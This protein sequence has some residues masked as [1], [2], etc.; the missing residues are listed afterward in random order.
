M[1]KRRGGYHDFS[2][3]FFCLTVP[4]NFVVEHFGV[5]ENFGYQKILCIR[6]GG[7]HVSPSKNLCHTVPKNFVGEHFGVSQ[8]FMHKRGISLNSVE[9]FLSH[10][11]DKIRRRTFLCFE[12]FLVSK[13]F[14]QRRGEEA[15]RFCQKNFL[16]HRTE[17]T[18]TGNHSVF[19]KTSGIEKNLWIRGDISRFSVD[20]FMPHSAEKF[21]KA[22]LL[23]LRKYLV[24]KSFMDENGGGGGV[25]RF[26]VENFL[27]HSVEKFRGH[28]FNVSENLGYRKILCI[29]G[30]I[31]FFRQKFLVS[32]CRKIY[33]ASLQCFR[34]FGVSKNSMHNRG[35]TFFRR[36]FCLTVPKKFVGIPS[37]F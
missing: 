4:K 19:Q 24:S 31:T 8:N 20:I 35:I 26:S 21:R 18:S 1:Q 25:S 17:K 30:A 28:P 33:W 9:K 10:S 3:K 15:S 27:S 13:F 36:K 2:F 37:M 7:Y 34:K 22:I 6:E 14:E 23:F 32:Q 16:S 5:S 11:A 29:I 12:R